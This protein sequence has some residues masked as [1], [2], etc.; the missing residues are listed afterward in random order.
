MDCC[1]K[2]VLSPAPA[3]PLLW[4]WSGAVPENGTRS[5]EW[6]LKCPSSHSLK[7]KKKQVE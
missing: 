7:C 6:H 1:P 2:L 5:Q 3:L 4:P